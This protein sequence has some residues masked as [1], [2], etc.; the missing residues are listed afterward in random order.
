MSTIRMSMGTVAALALTDENAR[1]I[2][3]SEDALRCGHI[4]LKGRKWFLNDADIVAVPRENV[5]NALPARAI[6]PGSMH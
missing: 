2:L 5:V 1:S 6:Y 4:F 3:L